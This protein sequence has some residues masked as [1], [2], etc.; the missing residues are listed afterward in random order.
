MRLNGEIAVVTGA[1]SGIG[2]G[3]ALA[4]AREGAA[5]AVGGRNAERGGEVVAEI[6]DAGGTA[7][8]VSAD[9][10]DPDA[11]AELVERAVAEFGGLT[12]LVN[13]AVVSTQGRDGPVTDVTDDAWHEIL[14]GNLVAPAALCRA[15]I[16]H[17]ISTGRGSIVNISS[18]AA[19]RGTPGH[20]AY[21]A[22]KG[23]LEALTRAISIDHA[24]DGIRCNVVRPGYVVNT[25]RDADMTDERRSRLEQMQLTRLPEAEDVAAAVVFLAG[26]ESATITGSVID[27]DGG[28]VTARAKVVG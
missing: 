22:S 20:A 4:L 16:P 5:V 3:I 17:M 10:A 7:V 23:G 25:R 11:R 8:F 2:R 1:T 9:L 19:I 13:N 28:S 27:V 15:A 12:V 14:A 6:V 26:R 21:A 18:R 24:S